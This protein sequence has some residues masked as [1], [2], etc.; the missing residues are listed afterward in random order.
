LIELVQRLARF[1]RGRLFLNL[2]TSSRRRDPWLSMVW[3][4]DDD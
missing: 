3:R 1:S 4:R 2:L